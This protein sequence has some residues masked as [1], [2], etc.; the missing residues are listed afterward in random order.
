MVEV[1]GAG[2]RTRRG[3]YW[4]DLRTRNPWGARM[5]RAMDVAGSLLLIVMLA[6]LMLSVMVSIRLTSDGPAVFRRRRIGF[7]GNEFGMFEFRTRFEGGELLQAQLAAT[8]SHY[9]DAEHDPRV[10]RVGRL[11][12]R[13]RL[14]ELPR[15][16]N[17]LEGTMSLAGPR[18]MLI[19]DLDRFPMRGL[20]RR[21]SVRPGVTGLWQVRGGDTKTDEERMQLDRDYINEWSLWLDLKILARTLFM[22]LGGRSA[23]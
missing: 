22:L 21:F 11:L 7:R 20:M 15:L 13:F 14:D 9:F 4:F 8:G 5:K 10:T 12:R 19:A 16:F 23:T 1:L 2:D 17:V 6:P 18:P 3:V